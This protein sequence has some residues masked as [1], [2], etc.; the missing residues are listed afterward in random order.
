M[1]LKDKVSSAA[2]FPTGVTSALK[3]LIVDIFEILKRT[4]LICDAFQL[5]KSKS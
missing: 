5:L 4:R 3:I 1:I 2:K